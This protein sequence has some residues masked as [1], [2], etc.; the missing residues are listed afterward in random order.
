V[1]RI[2]TEMEKFM[3]MIMA[4]GG[5]NVGYYGW[6]DCEGEYGGAR[7]SQTLLAAPSYVAPHCG[8]PPR[9]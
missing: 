4:E 5:D 8:T 7:Q 6:I 1:S 2:V 3:E 9:L